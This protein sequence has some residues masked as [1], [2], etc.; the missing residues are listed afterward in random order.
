MEYELPWT[1]KDPRGVEVKIQLWADRGK[2]DA[3]VR[4]LH[5]LILGTI[6]ESSDANLAPAP[7]AVERYGSEWVTTQ[8]DYGRG[9]LDA[10]LARR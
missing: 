2:G 1:T 8:L 9:V 5:G 10:R 6:D 4:I 3:E 7:D